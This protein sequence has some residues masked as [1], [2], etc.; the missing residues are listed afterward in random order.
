MTVRDAM[1]SEVLTV[2]PEHT[3]REASRL[4]RSRH[5]GAAV[6]VDPD[7]EGAG[8]LTERDVLIALADGADPDVETVAKHQTS[9]IVYAAPTWTLTQAAEAMLRGGFR[10]L[11]VLE[12][13]EVSGV[14]SVR[15]IV[16]MWAA[17]RSS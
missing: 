9:E 6:V 13:G 16:R 11:V 17:D 12:E 7:G 2:G 1:S 8:I 10:H 14:L 15:D 3:L 5:V 4:M